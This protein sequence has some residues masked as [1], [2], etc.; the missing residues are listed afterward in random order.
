MLITTDEN[1]MVL[2]L[3]RLRNRF[4]ILTFLEELGMLWINVTMSGNDNPY[5]ARDKFIALYDG[6]NN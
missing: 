2:R 6:E 4:A 3:N 5:F 1:E